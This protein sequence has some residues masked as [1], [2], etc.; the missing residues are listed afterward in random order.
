MYL[1]NSKLGSSTSHLNILDSTLS[2]IGS[3]LS[4][5]TKKMYSTRLDWFVESNIF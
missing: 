5:Y 2:P 4:H 3:P 1:K